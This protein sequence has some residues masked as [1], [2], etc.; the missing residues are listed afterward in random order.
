MSDPSP[1]VRFVSDPVVSGLRVSDSLDDGGISVTSEGIAYQPC[2]SPLEYGKDYF[3]R[4]QSLKGSSVARCLNQK[5]TQLLSK[6]GSRWNLDIGVGSGEFIETFEAGGGESLGY[7]VN[8]FGITWLRDRGCFFDPH[9]DIS[10]E[11]F[12]TATMWDSLEHLPNPS[13]LLKLLGVR[14][15][16]ISI[17]VINDF[18]FLTTWKHFKPDEHIFYFSERGLEFLMNANGFRLLEKN[19]MEE[20]CGREDIGTF[21][22]KNEKLS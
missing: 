13:C 17:P 20:E 8:P 22:F 5:R 12:D 7:D 9:H 16:F 6:Y 21:V 18:Q 1:S 3:D 11:I 15:I 4:Y 19:R 14:L 10:S 2:Y